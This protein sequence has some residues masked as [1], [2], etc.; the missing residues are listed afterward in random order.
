MIV[1]KL[2]GSFLTSDL[3][4][5]FYVLSQV[6]RLLRHLSIPESHPIRSG[7]WAAFEPEL[8]AKESPLTRNMWSGLAPSGRAAKALEH[9]VGRPQADVD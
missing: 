3:C 6:K 5:A 9:S 7:F 4:K 1:I 2:I 8:R